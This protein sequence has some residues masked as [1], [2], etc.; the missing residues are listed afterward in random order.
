MKDLSNLLET[1]LIAGSTVTGITYL[2]NQYNP[3]VAGIVSGVPISIPSMLLIKG[4]EKQK[5]FIHSAFLM[6]TLLAIITGL[7]DLL[8]HYT[9]MHSIN[10]VITTFLLWCI[11]AFLYYQYI[12]A[13]I[14]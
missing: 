7:T 6:V 11:G 1:F 2:G 13:K 3:L 9:N 10:I 5:K 12:N 8:M 4:R 14:K